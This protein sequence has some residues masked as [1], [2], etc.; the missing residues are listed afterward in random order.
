M[1]GVGGA[2]RFQN[3]FCFAALWILLHLLPPVAIVNVDLN[4]FQEVSILQVRIG[5][6]NSIFPFLSQRLERF[7][8][9][10]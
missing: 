7:K 5:L 3:R 1:R 6:Q 4:L 9:F 10:L 2:G 8:H